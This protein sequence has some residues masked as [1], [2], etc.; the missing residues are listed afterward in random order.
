MKTSIKITK[1]KPE[2]KII[3]WKCSVD[4]KHFA[5]FSEKRCRYC[6]PIYEE[7]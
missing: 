1:S 6:L 3:G 4:G 5:V 7:D 2:R